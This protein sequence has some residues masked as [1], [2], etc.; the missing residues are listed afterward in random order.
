MDPEL[1][2]LYDFSVPWSNEKNK[3]LL[4]LRNHF[5]TEDPGSGTTD[6]FCVRGDTSVFERYGKEQRFKG[7]H[8]LL[9]EAKTRD[10]YWTEPKDLELEDI[11]ADVINGGQFVYMLQETVGSSFRMISNPNPDDVREAF[12]FTANTLD[13]S[14][15]LQY[16]PRVRN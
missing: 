16:P 10:V 1:Y 4:S 11:T 7:V 12:Q 3:R 13:I 5:S 2:H 9:L 6:F 8:F 14:K 15:I